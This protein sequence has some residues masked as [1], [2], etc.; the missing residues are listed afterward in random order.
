MIGAPQLCGCC[1]TEI[2]GMPLHSCGIGLVC[3][4]CAEGIRVGMKA[5][6]RAGIRDLFIGDCPDNRKGG[7]K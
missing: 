4:G 3:R 5:L 1:R 2:K 6:A 7:P